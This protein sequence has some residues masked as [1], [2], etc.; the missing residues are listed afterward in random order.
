MKR[1]FKFYLLI[2]S[3]AVLNLAAANE[4]AL[5]EEA[6]ADTATSDSTPFIVAEASANGTTT[7]VQNQDTSTSTA[8][9]Q[10]APQRNPSS[11]G[12]RICQDAPPRDCIDNY[13]ETECSNTEQQTA[14]GDQEA[15][16]EHLRTAK[17]DTA[18]VSAGPDPYDSISLICLDSLEHEKAGAQYVCDNPIEAL[19][20]TAAKAVHGIS[21][22]SAMGAGI[23]GGIGSAS[24]NKLCNTMAMLSATGV[25]IAGLAR[26]KCK[27]K[28]NKCL[29]NC[30][31]EKNHICSA[32][33]SQKELCLTIKNTQ[34]PDVNTLQTIQQRIAR[35]SCE[36][37]L[38][39]EVKRSCKSLRNNIEGMEQDV[40][41]LVKT[42]LSAKACASLTGGKYTENLKTCKKRGGSVI[43]DPL[44]NLVCKE[45]PKKCQTTSDCPPNKMCLNGVCTT[46]TGICPNGSLKPCN[47]KCSNGQTPANCPTPKG[48]CS[49]GSSV[50]CSEK[51]PDGQTPADCPETKGQCSDGS[52]V[53]C[54]EKCPDG[55]TPADCPTPK[56]QCPDGSSVD[57]NEKCPN[58]QTPA[59]CPTPKGQCPDGSSVDC[60]EKCPDGQTPAD[61]PTPKG[62]CSDGSSV[63]CSE[64]CPDGQTPADCENRDP[65]NIPPRA[66]S[67]N[68]DCEES[69]KC[70]RGE[71]VN[72]DPVIP[73][74]GQAPIDTGSPDADALS[75]DGLGSGGPKN[76]PLGAKPKLDPASITLPT[77]TQITGTNES[78]GAGAGGIDGAGGGGGG[79]G[80]YGRGG[81]RGN[82]TDTGLPPFEEDDTM[83]VK[84]AGGGGF[85]GYGSGRRGRSTRGRL[86]LNK[87]QIKKLK[88]QKGAKRTLSTMEKKLGG[89]HHNIFERITKRFTRLCKNKI[90]CR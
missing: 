76:K 78:A 65:D 90:D 6:V 5:A 57:C 87:K 64:K 89:A 20:G 42:L 4:T 1:I 8:P 52:S 30:N 41:N 33:H 29:S 82:R 55:Q 46:V 71:C 3:C 22:Y 59:D 15:V 13:L 66:C 69:Q 74:S 84:G 11:I 80:S 26:R 17:A 53:A 56:G 48:Q 70:F 18:D 75:T 44:G 35:L 39:E 49:D 14:I 81:R 85:G 47:E 51:C 28:I 67:T 37:K 12:S 38:I 31:S 27:S 16:N 77:G 50:A 36:V 45:P 32:Y 72:E 10:T 7:N 40:F 23:A 73:L 24:M 43:T 2:L 62:K 60:N 83:A 68:N 21:Q 9:V 25:S 19:G 54:S 63:D 34:P 58:G 86:A 79:F 61:C 88:K